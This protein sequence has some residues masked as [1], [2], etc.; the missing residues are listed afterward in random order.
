MTCMSCHIVS[1]KC[2]TVVVVVVV[3]VVVGVVVIRLTQDPMSMS[4]QLHCICGTAFL[5]HL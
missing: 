5:F 1:L 4:T 3:V 2:S